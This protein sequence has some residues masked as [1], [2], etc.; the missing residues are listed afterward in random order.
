MVH[1]P[2]LTDTLISAAETAFQAHPHAFEIFLAAMS[3]LFLESCSLA[4]SV[5][6]YSLA[7]MADR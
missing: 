4:R 1:T 3:G 7:D 5:S 6:P 2:G